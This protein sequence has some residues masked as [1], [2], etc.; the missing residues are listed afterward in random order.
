LSQS[1][2][3]CRSGVGEEGLREEVEIER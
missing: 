3:E 2:L 1:S